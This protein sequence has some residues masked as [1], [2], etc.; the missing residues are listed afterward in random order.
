MILN[1]LLTMAQSMPSVES[2]VELANL[3]LSG[4]TIA[5]LVA[6]WRQWHV[7]IRQSREDYKE[8]VE[9]LLEI[10]KMSQDKHEQ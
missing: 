3:G 2:S 7:D 4:C 8:L 1:L 9:R 10:A 5:A 6:I